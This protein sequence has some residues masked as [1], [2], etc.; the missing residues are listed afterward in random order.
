MWCLIVVYL[1]HFLL[2]FAALSVDISSLP[3]SSGKADTIWYSSG[4]WGKVIEILT[5]VSCTWLDV[6]SLLVDDLVQII[7]CCLRQVTN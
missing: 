1:V 4:G 5:A 7:C 6:G 2:C 3:W